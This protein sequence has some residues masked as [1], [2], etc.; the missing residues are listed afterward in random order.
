MGEF[1][2][3]LERVGE[4]GGDLERVGDFGGDLA[5]EGD[6]LLVGDFDLSM[7]LSLE[8]IGSGSPYPVEGG[9]VERRPRP[10]SL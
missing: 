6:L 1:G 10:I 2:G 3:D 4:F 7:E 9:A 5:R 8:S